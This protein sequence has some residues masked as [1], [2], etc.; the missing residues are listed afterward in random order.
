MKKGIFKTYLYQLKGLPIK[1]GEKGTYLVEPELIPIAKIHAEFFIKRYE[2]ASS[3]HWKANEERDDYVGLL[4]Q[5]IFHV[6]LQQYNVPA[7]VNDPCIDWREKKDYDFLVPAVGK[8]EVKGFDYHRN[9]VLINKAD[10]HGSDYAVFFKLAD[11]KPREVIWHGY[12]TKQEVESLRISR[13]G[14]PYTP[15]ADAYITDFDDL[16]PPKAFIDLLRD[17]KQAM[18][19]LKKL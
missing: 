11:P 4:C 13:K 12:L 8:I 9:A 3:R 6:I 1:E 18:N 10:W 14:D 5:K 7:D 2:E 17:A 16:T 19:N 15:R